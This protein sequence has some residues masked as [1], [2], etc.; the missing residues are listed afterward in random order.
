MPTLAPDAADG[1]PTLVAT[2]YR[3]STTTPGRLCAMAGGALRPG[4]LRAHVDGA[5]VVHYPLTVPIPPAG[6]RRC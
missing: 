4:N 6:A 5:D 3:A 2:G 1:L